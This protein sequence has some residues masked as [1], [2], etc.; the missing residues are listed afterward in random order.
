MPEDVDESRPDTAPEEEEE[1]GPV[2]SFLEHLED[3][4]WVLIKSL[5]ALGVAFVVCLL[6]ADH[7]V[8]V[9]RWPLDRATISYPKDRQVVTFLFRTNRLGVFQVPRRDPGALALSTNQ[10]VTFHLDFEPG[11]E[12]SD[13]TWS[14]SESDFLARGTDE[15]PETNAPTVALASAHRVGPKPFKLVAQMDS[16]PTE[17]RKL[18]IPL[19]FFAPAAAFIVAVRVAAYASVL[20]ASPFVLYFV[21]SFVFPAL[22]LKERKYVY[23]GLFYGLG[24]FLAGVA[25]CYF[26]LMPVALTASVKYS[27]W[28][29]FTVDQWRAEDFISFVSKFMLGMGLGFEMPVV[30]LVLVK[31][32][33]LSYAILAK[34]RRYVILINLIL[35]AVLTTPEV[36]TQV[37][38]AL[39]LQLLYEITVWIAWYWE[40][41]EKK[42]LA[43]EAAAEAAAGQTRPA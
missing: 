27:L 40:R 20:V 41:K 24:L 25:F 30:V 16:D 4:R 3:L 42:R 36:L 33:V 13:D 2:K 22:K 11:A 39:P 32:G 8:K 17:A 7:V 38:M 34:G 14:P 43:A 6:A 37:L 9:L 18:A 1:G 5:A 21:A 10:F 23:R 31:I 29:G 35:G 15:P 12:L 26:M 19:K 28:L